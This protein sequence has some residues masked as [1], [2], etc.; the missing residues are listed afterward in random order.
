M[1]EAGHQF[2]G[3]RPSGRGQRVAGMSQVVEIEDAL[4]RGGRALHPILSARRGGGVD[5]SHSSPRQRSLDRL[6]RLA[7][8]RGANPNSTSKPEMP[9]CGARRHAEWHDHLVNPRTIRAWGL[10]LLGLYG[11]F[12]IYAWAVCLFRA[13]P[14]EDYP[15]VAALFSALPWLLL[16]RPVLRG[17]E[18]GV[19]QGV[20]AAGTIV[21]LLLLGLIVL[22]GHL[23]ACREFPF[24]PRE[25]REEQPLGRSC[26]SEDGTSAH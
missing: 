2:P 14:E 9:G 19:V 7:P 20:M 3:A 15:C 5:H 4:D 25:G 22:V 10:T 11:A 16:F 21:N 13:A 12:A 18:E 26:P 23:R 24:M 1:A 17:A 8:T 6:E